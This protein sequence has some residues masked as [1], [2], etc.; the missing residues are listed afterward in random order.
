MGGKLYTLIIENDNFIID[1]R[2]FNIG[3]KFYL[4]LLY[5]I[6]LSFNI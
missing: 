3:F 5:C 1:Y 6:I 2:K 4:N